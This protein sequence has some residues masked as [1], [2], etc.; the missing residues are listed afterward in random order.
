MAAA[1]SCRADR[2][3]DPVAPRPRIV[4]PGDPPA[5]VSFA[6]A[7]QAAL[8]AVL[9]RGP[10]SLMVVAEIP[11]AGIM[12]VGV[13]GGRAVV[14]GLSAELADVLLPDDPESPPPHIAG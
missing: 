6:E 2:R 5:E 8:Q 10:V 11:G 12:W 3:L 4:Q 7:A 1:C 13:P 14:R 9:A